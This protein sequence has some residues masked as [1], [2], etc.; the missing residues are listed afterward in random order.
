MVGM[1]T[2]LLFLNM[3]ARLFLHITYYLVSLQQKH[4]G[5][6]SA[7]GGVPRPSYPT[8]TTDKAP[9]ALAACHCSLRSLATHVE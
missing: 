1:L 8:S 4:G 6:R 9:P 2:L 5:A 3:T 7:G